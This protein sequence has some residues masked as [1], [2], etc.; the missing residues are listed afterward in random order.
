MR[1]DTC[2]GSEAADIIVTC[3]LVVGIAVLLAL[4]V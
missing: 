2:L 3:I 1:K 4:G